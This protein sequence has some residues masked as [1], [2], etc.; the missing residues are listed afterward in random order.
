MKRDQILMRAVGAAHAQKI[1]RQY[2][3]FET[4]LEPVVDKLRQ[5]RARFGLDL[6][7]ESLELFLHHL[8][9]RRLVRTPPREAKNSTVADLR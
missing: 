9:E 4:S 5:A 3:A 6:G 8:I 7:N 1:V 2:A